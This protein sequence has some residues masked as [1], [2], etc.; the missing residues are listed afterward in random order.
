MSSPYG[1]ALVGLG[2]FNLCYPRWVASR[3]KTFLLYGL[4]ILG[5]CSPDLDFLPGIFLGNPGRFHHGPIHSLGTM[6]GLSLLAGF[7]S[8]F[9]GGNRSLLKT[10]GFVFVLIGS[11]LFLDYITTTK[12]LKETF[13]FPFFWPFSEVYFISSWG[14][15]PYV[16]RNFSNPAIWSQIV[17]VFTVESLLFIP[18]FLFSLWVRGR[19]I[20]KI[21]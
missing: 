21:I 10:A 13:G 15:L 11:H 18:F 5:A 6:V 12:D 2:L 17:R 7:L 20:K 16:E 14:F 1:H 19:G 9:W 8:T 3:K 4:V